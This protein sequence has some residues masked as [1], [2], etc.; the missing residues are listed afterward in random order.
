M[1]TRGGVDVQLHA[2][3]TLALDGNGWSPSCPGPFTPVQLPV[4]TEL[5]VGWAPKPV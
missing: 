5:G 3:L 4:T 1:K 2:F